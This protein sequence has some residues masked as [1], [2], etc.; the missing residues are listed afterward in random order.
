MIGAALDDFNGN[1]NTP[2]LNDKLKIEQKG[3]LLR[4]AQA[5]KGET[6]NKDEIQD[7]TSGLSCDLTLK[8]SR[9]NLLESVTGRGRDPLWQ[10]RVEQQRG[11]QGDG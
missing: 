2:G 3:G 9:R 4:E 7:R 8:P 10:S 11:L 5:E 1:T 6:F